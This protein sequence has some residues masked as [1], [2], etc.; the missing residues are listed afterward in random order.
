LPAPAES[1]Y[2]PR[3]AASLVFRD[4]SEVSERLSASAHRLYKWVKAI[5]PDKTDERAA[6]LIEASSKILKRRSQLKRTEE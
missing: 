6:A 1:T 2:G 4:K 3:R 5:K